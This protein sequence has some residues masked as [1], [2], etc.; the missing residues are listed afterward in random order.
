MENKFKQTHQQQFYR[1]LLTKT[2]EKYKDSNE[3]DL[4]VFTHDWKRGMLCIRNY[5]VPP[6]TTVFTPRLLWKDTGVEFRPPRKVVAGPTNLHVNMGPQTA[7]QSATI[8]THLLSFWAFNL[9]V[10]KNAPTKFWPASAVFTLATFIVLR[11]IYWLLY[12]VGQR[13]VNEAFHRGTPKLHTVKLVDVEGKAHDSSPSKLHRYYLMRYDVPVGQELKIQF[14]VNDNHQDY[15][16][17][18]CYSL[19]GIPL[20]NMVY[21]ENVIR[22]NEKIDGSY[23]VT[24]YLSNRGK[25][26]ATNAAFHGFGRRNEIDVSSS[27]RGNVLNRIVHPKDEAFV[28]AAK[29]QILGLQP[30]DDMSEKKIN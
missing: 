19:Y 20:A 26:L 14:Q 2:P 9:F 23:T 11:V 30:I 7:R 28:A 4:I 10:W 13:R 5:L 22:E 17:F 12:C 3:Y 21:D 24:L 16:S 1:I 29:P 15:W 6:G 8:I 25:H 18:V 27:P